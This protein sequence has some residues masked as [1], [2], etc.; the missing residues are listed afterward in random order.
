MAVVLADQ[1]VIFFCV[2]CWED[3]I[4]SFMTIY[5]NRRLAGE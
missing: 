1:E 2:F 5:N 3:Y 4:W